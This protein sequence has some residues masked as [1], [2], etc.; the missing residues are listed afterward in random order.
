MLG[1]VAK[2]LSSRKDA[3]NAKSGS[4]IS[5]VFFAGFAPLRE[6]IRFFWS[7]SILLSVAAAIALPGFTAAGC[8]REGAPPAPAQAQKRCP[9]CPACPPAEAKETPAALKASD[10]PETS[11]LYHLTDLYVP[12]KFSH[13]AHVSYAESCDV[14]HHHHSEV[15]RTPPC[16]ECHGQPF[17]TLSKPGLKGAYHRQCMNCHRESGSGPLGCEECHEKRKGAP[18][19]KEAQPIGIGTKISLGH[20]AKEHGPVAFDHKLHLDMADACSECHH[21]Q[22]EVEK[23]PPC[24]E[25]HNTRA[26]VKGEKKLGLMD[27]YHKQCLG[28]HKGKGGGPQ[29]CDGCHPKA[30]G[31]K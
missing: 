15:E 9:P 2:R 21:H 27:A 17:K 31:K 8:Q 22:G 24:R 25:C 19:A 18:A 3:K 29:G 16:R 28:C 14:C 5:L 7:E 23:T 20:I 12:V 30:N 13:K 4:L 6:A 10:G 26:T 1:R 11:V